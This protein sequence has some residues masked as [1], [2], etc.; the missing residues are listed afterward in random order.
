MSQ[1]RYFTAKDAAD[2]LEISMSTLYSYVSR[3]LIRSEAVNGDHRVRR[4]YA[5]DI[6]KIKTRK[7]H[8]RN[9]AKAAED[10]LHWGLPV[11]ESALT[12]ITDNGVY[13]RGQS[14]FALA[15][16]HS[17]EQVA[18]LMW[19]GDLGTADRLF[20]ASPLA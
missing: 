20:A 13:Y 15:A 19:T 1:S 7:A 3:G 18:A 4:Y 16:T 9:P 10:A 5:E 8:R 6:E 11:L 14:V 12:L 17:F 2:V